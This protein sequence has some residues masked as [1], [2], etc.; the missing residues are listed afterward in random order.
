MFTP[1]KQYAPFLNICNVS[2]A[3]CNM[4]LQLM[5][6]TRLPKL[7]FTKAW[8]ENNF[9]RTVFDAHATRF[10]IQ[11]TAFYVLLLLLKLIIIHHAYLQRA[12]PSRNQNASLLHEWPDCNNSTKSYHNLKWKKTTTYKG[13]CVI[14]PMIQWCE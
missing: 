4:F 13:P 7:S 1:R 11:C 14:Y 8:D 3:I 5:V 9:E 10:P 2:T 12:T 6:K